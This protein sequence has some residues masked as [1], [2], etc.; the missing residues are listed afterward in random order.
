MS[1]L[2]ALYDDGDAAQLAV[3]AL[4]AGGVNENE[5]TVISAE[6]MEDYEFGGIDRHSRL[7]YI[8]SAGGAFGCVFATWLTR[9]TEIAWPLSTGN[10]PIVAWWPNLI[11]IFELTMLGAILS[12]VVT[13]VLTGGL[14]R[15][16]P[17]LY[18]DA[19]G[20][21]KILVGVAAPRD[22]GAVERALISAGSP[23]V[24]R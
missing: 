24:S 8:A 17:P 22:R 14:A 6:P 16:L 5:I 10:M 23:V 18:D 9:F 2:Y 3:D 13:L 19:V 15:R 21:G 12:T 11:V 1:A 4:R 7:W 20:H